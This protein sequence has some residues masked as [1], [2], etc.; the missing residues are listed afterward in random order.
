[1]LSK[2]FLKSIEKAGIFNAFET[3]DYTAFEIDPKTDDYKIEF[4]NLNFI[5]K[6][7]MNEH[8]QVY[9]ANNIAHCFQ[10]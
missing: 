1:M 9:G 10:E 6:N 7:N 3:T 2:D 4:L 8:R 5:N